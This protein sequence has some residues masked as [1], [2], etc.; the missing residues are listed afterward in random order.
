MKTMSKINNN[1][2]HPAQLSSSRDVRLHPGLMTQISSTT[3][4][5]HSFVEICTVTL[6]LPSIPIR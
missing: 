2:I 6:I 4:E 5:E 3:R 1:N